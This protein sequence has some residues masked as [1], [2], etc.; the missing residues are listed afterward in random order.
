M[1]TSP[2]EFQRQLRSLFA[3][4][5]TLLRQTVEGRQSVEDYSAH[6]E[7]RVGCLARAHERV[8]RSPDAGVDLQETVC[9]ELLAQTIA[10]ARYRVDGPD[11][12][13]AQTSAAALALAFHE[14][15]VNAIEH[16]ALGKPQGRAEVEWRFSREARD[17][18]W[19]R[20]RWIE[21][22]V[23]L[24]QPRPQRKGFGFELIERMLPYEL[25][26]RT[27]IDLSS[28]GARVELLIP[29]LCAGATIWRPTSGERKLNPGGPRYE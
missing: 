29:S 9:G 7:G 27:L 17:G 12:R 26:A 19:L 11:I 16:G 24:A 5:R 8:L 18:E 10:E 21:R 20:V 22:G 13:I 6:L 28:E 2:F 23:P 3:I 4:L 25:G 1:Q 15:V 14:L